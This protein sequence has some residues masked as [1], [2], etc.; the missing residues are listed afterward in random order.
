MNTE[1][2]PELANTIVATLLPPDPTEVLK[3]E[4]ADLKKQLLIANNQIWEAKNNPD[5]SRAW[6]V[7]IV[8]LVEN[9]RGD[10]HH[11]NYDDDDIR[12]RVASLVENDT[13]DCWSPDREYSFSMTM[14]ITLRGNIYG[15]S[16]DSV[17]E[18]IEEH[19]PSYKLTNIGGQYD[20]LVIE[21]EVLSDLDIQEE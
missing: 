19:L 21:D 15:N 17:R 8:D 4:I 12:Q 20:S 3:K 13:H 16:E 5:L 11:H 14:Q 7:V 9:T 6:S 18:W 1:V 2:T 10:T